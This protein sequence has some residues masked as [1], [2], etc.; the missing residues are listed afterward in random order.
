MITV[1]TGESQDLGLSISG[2]TQTNNLALSPD[3]RYLAYTEGVVSWETWVMDGF[4]PERAA[5]K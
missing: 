4:L 3:G 1:P 5:E 2:N